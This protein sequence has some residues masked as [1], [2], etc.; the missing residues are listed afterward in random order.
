[1]RFLSRVHSRGALPTVLNL[2]ELEYARMRTGL[3]LGAICRAEFSADLADSRAAA[4]LIRGVARKMLPPS[5]NQ[6]SCFPN[7]AMLCRDSAQCRA[8]TSEF[9]GRVARWRTAREFFANAFT[10]TEGHSGAYLC[11]SRLWHRFF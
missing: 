8:D 10:D 11:I 1:M 5:K 9:P 6:S 3:E 7:I 2:M 4:A